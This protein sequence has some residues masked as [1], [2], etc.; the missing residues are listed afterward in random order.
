MSSSSEP[1]TGPLVELVARAADESTRI[2]VFD[3]DLHPIELAVNLGEVKLR[4]A[5]GVYS[6]TFT[7]GNDSRR[8][9][10]VLTKDPVTVALSE[11]EAPRFATAAPVRKTSSTREFHRFPARDLSR[12]KPL[13]P[14]AGHAGGSRLF[15]FARDLNPERGGDL[16]GGLSVRDLDGKLVYDIATTRQRDESSC[17]AGA[18]LDLDPGAY[19]LRSEL[20]AGRMT[21]QTLYTRAGWQTQVFLLSRAAGGEGDRRRT[22][23][24]NVSVLMAKTNVG[25]DFEREDLRWGEVALSALADD[26]N[27]P[28]TL[29]AEMLW[30]KFD[31][32][33]LGILAALL[34]LRRKKNVDVESMREVVANLLD[35]VGPLPDVL[36]IGW[37]LAARDPSV[38]KDK[39][40]AKALEDPAG[41]A[42]PPM[43]AESWLH[44]MRASEHNRHL[45][46][47]GSLSDRVGDL[48]W[49]PGPWLAWR[50]APPKTVDIGDPTTALKKAAARVTERLPAETTEA[51]PSLVAAFFEKF[52]EP[53]SELT[54]ALAL[55]YLR[56]L[57]GK[58]PEAGYLLVSRRYT[59]LERRIAF[60]VYPKAAPA[61][62]ELMSTSRA[63]EAALADLAP[64]ETKD[65][66]KNEEHLVRNTIEA[67]GVPAS[68]L[69]RGTWSVLKKLLVEPV[70]P[71]KFGAESF[72]VT[73]ARGIDAFRQIL[74]S[75]ASDRTPLRPKAGGPH[76][77]ALAFLCMC[78]RGSP[79]YPP[80]TT[81]TLKALAALLND[82]DYVWSDK[83]AKVSAAQ[84]SD[85]VNHMRERITDAIAAAVETKTIDLAPDWRAHVLPPVTAYTR[86]ALLPAPRQAKTATTGQKAAGGKE[87]TIAGTRTWSRI[88]DGSS[89]E[90][91]VSGKGLTA[92]A[93]LSGEGVNV[94]KWSLVTAARARRVTLRSPKAY[95]LNV[96]VVFKRKGSGS[97]SSQ[98]V[99]PD[100]TR[101]GKPY[102]LPLSGE[103][104]QR[105]RVQIRALT[106]KS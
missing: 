25:F 78:Y 72:A 33:I 16:V 40:I 98:I 88:P 6:V 43:L 47:P 26:G 49:A 36:A 73:E 81:H 103:K 80:E 67:I 17:W 68:T 15:V 58:N 83:L 37:A 32:P 12:A 46:P 82:C 28:A 91:R 64:A 75:L 23:L 18:H 87:T 84:L 76:A 71:L 11:D 104:G 101:F 19:L 22:D 51:K 9:T 97:L 85:Y 95:T 90:L 4:L 92:D 79:A 69:L 21:E 99:K 106:M 61:V 62:L 63:L 105:V 70:V 93:V 41:L 1:A 59:D 30:A 24:S 53:F 29:R 34:Q 56:S 94:R 5:P 52:R 66:K 50:G 86:G 48:Q 96:D 89:M 77:S 10:A 55:P 65:D 13:R 7:R 60:Y 44:L 31:N 8:K 42:T 74:S 54:A 45:I 14:R 38:L 100:G 20:R 39:K 2:D 3:G 57:L 102:T 35:L 27:V